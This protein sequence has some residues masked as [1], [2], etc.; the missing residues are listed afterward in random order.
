MTPDP[1]NAARILNLGCGRKRVEGAVNLDLTPE[2]APDVVHD[3]N[4]RP[5]PFPDGRFEEVLAFDVIEHLDSVIGTFEEIHRVCAHG[6][7]VRVTVPHFS[8]ANAYVDPTHQ[9]PFGWGTIDYVTGA[10]EFS[11]YT[12]VRF[13]LA[14]RQLLFHPSLVNK[15]L[16]RL[17]N[18]WPEAYERRWAW[19][20]PAWYLYLELEVDKPVPP[21][22]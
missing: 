1:P 16:W 5:W 10:A 2:T 13:R 18:R 21:P 12:R 6:A 11:F 20:F 4:A 8:S 22:P 9:H 17:A 15:L 3:L 19:I 7:R 14:R